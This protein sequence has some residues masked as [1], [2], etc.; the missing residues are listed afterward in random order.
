MRVSGIGIDR[1][2]N[3]LSYWLEMAALEIQRKPRIATSY[4]GAWISWDI[5]DDVQSP[6]KYTKALIKK[7]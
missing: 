7:K 5:C 3:M 6:I 4:H 1:A 2:D